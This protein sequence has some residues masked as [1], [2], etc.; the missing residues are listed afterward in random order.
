MDLSKAKPVITGL[1]IA[2]C[3]IRKSSGTSTTMADV[4]L[5]VTFTSFLAKKKKTVI[6]ANELSI[7]PF[8]SKHH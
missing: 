6:L 5:H 4:S 7:I 1:A 8:D 2:K 3:A